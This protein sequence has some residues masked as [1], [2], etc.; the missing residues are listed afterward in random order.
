MAAL[1]MVRRPA[2]LLGAAAAVVVAVLAHP[3]TKAKVATAQR[4][5]ARLNG[6]FICFV[7]I[8]L[9]FLAKIAVVLEM[10]SSGRE[11]SRKNVRSLR[12]LCL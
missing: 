7:L 5:L 1:W 12:G 4:R 10:V 8:V 9:F 6:F 11:N 3:V 2:F